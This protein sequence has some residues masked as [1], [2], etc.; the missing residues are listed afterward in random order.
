MLSR[1]SMRKHAMKW[2]QTFLKRIGGV[3]NINVA[4]TGVDRYIQVFLSMML[5]KIDNEFKICAPSINHWFVSSFNCLNI[6]TKL[7]NGTC[8][9]VIHMYYIRTCTCI[10]LHVHVLI[11]VYTKQLLKNKYLIHVDWFPTAIS[12]SQSIV[13]SL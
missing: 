9:F 2:F 4:L 1:E 12:N 8:R 5:N 13:W 6:L 11:S 10:K 7:A 3:W